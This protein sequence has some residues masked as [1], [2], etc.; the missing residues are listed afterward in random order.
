LR[1]IAET[2]DLA[3]RVRRQRD[4]FVYSSA[5]LDLGNVLHLRRR[6]ATELV[7]RGR[8]NAKYS[9]GGV[10]DVE[11]FVQSWQILVGAADAT[12]RVANTRDAIGRLRDGGYFSA[13]LARETAATYVFLRNLIDAL[14]VVRGN[15]KDLTIPPESSP[16][17]A[18]LAQRSG[19]AGPRELGD[20]LTTRMA[21]ARS[22]WQNAPPRYGLCP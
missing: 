1:P 15:A 10:V 13:G 20:T 19:L 22:L 3:E 8:V 9:P 2:S 12:V 17:F 7:P 21:F 14:R 5:P 6:Q 18:Y 4:A 11:Y 16:E